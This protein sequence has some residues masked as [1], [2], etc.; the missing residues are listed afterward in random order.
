MQMNHVFALLL[1]LVWCFVVPVVGL[2]AC[3]QDARGQPRLITS[4]SPC[5]YIFMCINCCVCLCALLCCLAPG[6]FG[7]GQRSRFG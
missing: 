6:V 5:S 3:G 2:L 7:M 1:C 4:D